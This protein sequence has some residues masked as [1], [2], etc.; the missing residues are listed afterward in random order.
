MIRETLQVRR[1]QQNRPK[2]DTGIQA[3]AWMAVWKADDLRSLG[4]DSMS[5]KVQAG[6]V[7]LLGH[8]VKAYHRRLAENLVKAVPG[9]KRVHNELVIDS[10]LVVEIAQALAADPRT[11][12]YIIPIGAS[13]GWVQ[14]G[15][16]VPA[17]EVRLA[18][19]EVAASVPS[20]RG[21]L[22][23]P[24]LPGKTS[25]TCLETGK[26]NCLVQPQIGDR[27]Y[28]KD[29]PAGK[30]AAV[31]INP[32]NRLVSHITVEVSYELKGRSITGK[33]IIPAE[34]IEVGSEG[35][36]F[37]FDTLS[38]LAR[39]PVYE[40][41]D[42]RIAPPEWRLPY[43]YKPGAVRWSVKRNGTK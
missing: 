7:W 5:V 42:F 15:G 2:S 11:R 28:A 19:E 18:V 38:D 20:V 43:P 24:H 1:K 29:G 14:L 30:V 4:T 34:A 26:R 35:S 16:E 23:L 3:E 32:C 37:L 17:V 10:D 31:I 40:E 8:V 13:H 6:D 25:H 12:P 39:R 36:L 41:A 33:F 22:T 27:V 21:V 9:V